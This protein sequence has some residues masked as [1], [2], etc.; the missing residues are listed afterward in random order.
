MVCL[1]L[2]LPTIR[3]EL[4][5]YVFQAFPVIRVAIDFGYEPIPHKV[6]LLD[7]FH[8]SHL[9]FGSLPRSSGNPEILGRPGV[10]LWTRD[11]L[12]DLLDIHRFVRTGRKLGGKGFGPLQGG[13]GSL[14]FSTG[15]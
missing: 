4:R 1:A 9:K 14:R 2:L 8:A 5:V 6:N 3:L 10:E 15:P 11:L 13:T 7:L 12:P